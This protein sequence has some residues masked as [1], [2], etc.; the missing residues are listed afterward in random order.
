M[1]PLFWNLMRLHVSDFL[2]GESVN[3][4]Y[5]VRNVLTPIHLLPIVAAAHK[6]KKIWFAHGRLADI[7]IKSCAD[8]TVPDIRVSGAA[9]SLF[10]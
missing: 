8:E 3:D 6:Q 7:Q 2:A 9:L 1:I 4:G 10:T 5:F